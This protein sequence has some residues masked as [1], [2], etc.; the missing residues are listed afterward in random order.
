MNAAVSLVGST[1]REKE[2]A[3]VEG[4]NDPAQVRRA[5]GQD[6][7]LHASSQPYPP[8]SVCIGLPRNYLALEAV[9]LW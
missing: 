9:E 6:P 7:L 2:I 8:A 1:K 5:Q 3:E 4:I